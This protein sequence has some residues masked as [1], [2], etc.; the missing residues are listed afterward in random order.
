MVLGGG[1][2]RAVIAFLR[3]L[4][5]CGRRAFIAARTPADRVLRTQFRRDVAWVRPTDDL[6]MDVFADCVAHI[7]SHGF[8]GTLVVFPSTEYLNTFL[9]GHRASI[10]AMGCEIPLV[11]ERLYAQLTG[12]RSA[13]AF[14]A[15]AGI[16]PPHEATAGAAGCAAPVVAKPLANV[17]ASGESLYPHLLATDADVAAFMREHDPGEY[18]LQEYVHGESH[19]LLFFLSRDGRTELAWSQRNLLQQPD[20]KSMLLAEASDFHRSGTAR[21]ILSALR[22]V[23]F[24]GLGMVEVMRAPGR[25]VF[26]EMNPRIW[27]PAQFC[28][29]Q[30]QPLLQSFIGDVLEDD[31]TRY[32]GLGAPPRRQRYFWL[33]GTVAAYRAGHRPAWHA[34]PR[35]FVGTVLGNLGSD[36]YLRRDS[37]RCFL[38]DLAIAIRAPRP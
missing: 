1:N 22:D 27:G 15:A 30:R 19:Y 28:L 21:R 31:A 32:A 29:D 23:G 16:D 20:G 3:A 14:F 38:Y 8:T 10:E 17:S 26:I 7:R 36:V 18:F 2:D 24:H 13:A 6:D 34:T 12:K 11:P 4:R 25:D 33:G 35:S 9:L 5:A 37:W